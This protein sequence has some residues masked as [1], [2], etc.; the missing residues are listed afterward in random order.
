M[1]PSRRRPG[2]PFV[3]DRWPTDPRQARIEELP[4]SVRTMNRLLDRKFWVG[5]TF[6]LVREVVRQPVLAGDL[7]ALK[8]SHLL[9]LP[10][11]G[12]ISL[13]EVESWLE[14]NGMKLGSRVLEPSASPQVV[15]I[16]YTNWRGERSV[17]RILPRELR[18][19]KTE[20]HPE[21]QWLLDAIDLDKGVER[22]F[23]MKDIHAW[24][25]SSLGAGAS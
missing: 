19:D 9:R 2:A 22:T 5:R 10:G 4:F 23:A 11:F 7:E 18:F 6:A 14:A 21:F 13:L 16:D 8:P 15:V 25:P 20:H 1:P 3:F 12:R 24:A 17:R